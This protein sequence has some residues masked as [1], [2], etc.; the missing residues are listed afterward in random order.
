VLRWIEARK[1]SY[2]HDGQAVRVVGVNVDVT[3]QKRTIAQLRAFTETLEEGVKE[4][5]RTLETETKRGRGRQSQKMEG[6]GQ[7]TGGVAHDF[8]SLLTLI[9]GGLD[10]FGRQVMTLST[11]PAHDTDCSRQGFGVRECGACHQT[12]RPAA[13]LCAPAAIGAKDY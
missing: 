11:S 13:G 3:E 10:M 8:N 6:I 7:L 1:V 5:T 9:Q 12:D 2:V 4:R